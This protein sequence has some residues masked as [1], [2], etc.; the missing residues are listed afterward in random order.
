MDFVGGFALRE[1][2][3]SLAEPHL[4]PV[5]ELCSNLSCSQTWLI[6]QWLVPFSF[7]ICTFRCDETL[8]SREVFITRE[9]LSSVR[10]WKLLSLLGDPAGLLDLS[11]FPPATSNKTFLG[12]CW[13]QGYPWLLF[14]SD[15]K[16]PNSK[17]WVW[18][19]G[20]VMSQV[21][22]FL[23]AECTVRITGYTGSNMD[24]FLSPL[25][26]PLPTFVHKSNRKRESLNFL[27]CFTHPQLEFQS[28]MKM[29]L[30][31][32]LHGSLREQVFLCCR[33]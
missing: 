27:N 29:P 5:W 2:W 19:L 14:P 26:P 21:L 31:S 11:C 1:R 4:Q 25:S 24:Q 13:T 18:A 32:T 6:S 22:A 16:N 15:L 7:A 12:W 28:K 9:N 10:A 20:G 8:L 33:V 17:M 30:K 3:Q 23:N